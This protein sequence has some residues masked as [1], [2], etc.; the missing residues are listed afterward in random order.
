LKIFLDK[1]LVVNGKLNIKMI[2][3]ILKEAGFDPGGFDGKFGP[4]TKKAILD[5]QEVHGL[6][7]DGK[8]GYI[9]LNALSNY[10]KLA[11]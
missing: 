1:G 5:F 11:P 4:K 8:I 10:V 6:K 3:T 7:I 9:T 2:Q